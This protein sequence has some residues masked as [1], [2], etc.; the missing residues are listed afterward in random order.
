MKVDPIYRGYKIQKIMYSKNRL[1]CNC[2][3]HLHNS[4]N[5]SYNT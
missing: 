5:F 4:V 2:P 1:H 3:N